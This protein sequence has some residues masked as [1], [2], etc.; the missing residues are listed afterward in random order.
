MNP[1]KQQDVYLENSGF[2][3]QSN[4]TMPLERML[5]NM[6]LNLKMKM[7]SQF[8]YANQVLTRCDFGRGS[9]VHLAENARFMVQMRSSGVMM[10]AR[11]E[12]IGE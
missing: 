2:K 8:A 6:T 7:S 5:H 12:L 9:R 11:T 1:T 10:H 4:T 3:I